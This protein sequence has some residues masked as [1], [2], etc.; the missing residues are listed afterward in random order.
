MKKYILL[1]LAL[2]CG[3]VCALAQSTPPDVAADAVGGKKVT[4]SVT[5]NGT[6]P[7]TYQWSKATLAAPTAFAPLPSAT[8][9]ELVLAA[10]TPADAGIYRVVIS[11]SAGS[12]TSPTATVR[13]I[14]LPGVEAFTVTVSAE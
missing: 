2:L 8:M 4:I 1:T 14:T 5:A 7:F 6:A 9:A 3:A 10:I 11:N 12:I 13:V